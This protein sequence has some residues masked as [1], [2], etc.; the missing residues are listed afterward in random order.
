LTVPHHA[1]SATPHQKKLLR[2][3]IESGAAYPGTYAALGTGMIGNYA[4]NSMVNREN[5]RPSTQAAAPV[6][7]KKCASCHDNRG[8]SLPRSLSDET[9]VSFWQPRIGDRRLNTRRHI[10]FNL[11]RPDKT[12]LLL[13]PL[14]RSAGSWELCRDPKSRKPAPV[15]LSTGDPDY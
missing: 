15:F 6:F 2:L 8:R 13:A 7:E 1:V 10:V 14:A 5:E 9:G 3:W 11:S 4:E 12:I